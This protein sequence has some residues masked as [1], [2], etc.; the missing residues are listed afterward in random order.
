MFHTRKSSDVGLRTQ[1]LNGRLATERPR[2]YA[3]SPCCDNPHIREGSPLTSPDRVFL[4]RD[5]RGARSVVPR[6]ARP[7]VATFTSPFLRGARE[8]SA[9]SPALI[10]GGGSIRT[11]A[12]P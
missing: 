1:N 12:A 5:L 10:K 3:R 9:C 7:A 11:G 4:N 6:A 2:A 8:S